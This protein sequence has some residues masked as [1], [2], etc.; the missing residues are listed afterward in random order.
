MKKRISISGFFES[1]TTRF[2]RVRMNKVEKVCSECGKT[3]CAEKPFGTIFVPNCWT[4][5]GDF[6]FY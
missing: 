1:Q 2:H 6:D 4:A 3:V 5:R